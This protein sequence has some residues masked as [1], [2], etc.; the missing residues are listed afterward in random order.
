M[1]GRRQKIEISLGP[2]GV[3]LTIPF[4]LLKKM[5]K[6]RVVF[7]PDGGKLTPREQQVFSGI[8][9]AQSNKEIADSLNL[10]ERTVKFH[11][12]SLLVKYRVGSRNELQVAHA[13]AEGE[14]G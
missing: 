11:V 9:R 2:E 7:C 5:L 14:R 1:M 13:N 4:D 12:S 3:T 8:L 6:P 10:S